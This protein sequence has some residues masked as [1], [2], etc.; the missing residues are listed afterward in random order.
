MRAR[1][2][3]MKRSSFEAAAA[4]AL[5]V[6]SASVAAA[7]I[8]RPFGTHPMTYAA[9]SIRPDHLSQS[10]LDTAVSNFYDDWKAEYVTQACGAGRYVVL[11]H[12]SPGNLTVSEGHGYG[13]MLM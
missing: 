5:A 11:T 10:S 7:D 4:L 3:P 6:L 13:M 12:T 9:G 2:G 8:N 1:G